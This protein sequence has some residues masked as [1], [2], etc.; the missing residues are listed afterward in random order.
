MNKR[1]VDLDL[2]KSMRRSPCEN[3]GSRDR[4][5]GHHI[6]TQ[7]S[8]GGDVIHNLIPLCFKCHFDIHLFGNSRFAK[9]NFMFMNFLILN[10]WQLCAIRGKW[11]HE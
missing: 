10:D 2:I 7:G 8:G 3:C 5:V 1:I 6:K 9:D 11:W 4:V